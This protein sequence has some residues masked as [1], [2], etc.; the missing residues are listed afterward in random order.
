[1]A[2]KRLQ[3]KKIDGTCGTCDNHYAEH[4]IGAM[5]KP[6]LCLCILKDHAM[7]MSDVCKDYKKQ[8]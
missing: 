7:L 5:G 8:D 1:M 3:E 2:K 4:N 6:I